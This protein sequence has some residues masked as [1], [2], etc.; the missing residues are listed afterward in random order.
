MKPLIIGVYGTGQSGKSIFCGAFPKAYKQAMNNQELNIWYIS[1]ST[2]IKKSVQAMTGVKMVNLKNYLDD[3]TAYDFAYDYTSNDLSEKSVKHG[4]SE[5]SIGRI[6]QD[7]ALEMKEREG[8]NYWID[9]ALRKIG[10]HAD[11]VILDGVRYQSDV[12]AICERGGHIVKVYRED[13]EISGD[14]DKNHVSET[15]L[16]VYPFKHVFENPTRDSVHIANGVMRELIFK[17]YGG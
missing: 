12:L 2:D 3:Y 5:K 14:R 11:V 8:E 17:A 9:K 4:D 7:Y 13:S 10:E 1:M 6:L 15:E 16:A